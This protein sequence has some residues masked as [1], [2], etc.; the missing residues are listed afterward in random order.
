M[1]NGEDLKADL[2]DFVERFTEANIW[3]AGDVM[4]DEYIVGDVAR[5]SPEAPVQVVQVS[6]SFARLGGAANVARSISALAARVRLYG[7]VGTDPAGDEV[8]RRCG[9]TGIDATAVGRVDQHQTIRKTRIL[10]LRQQLLRLDWE[11]NDPC[12][13]ALSKSLIAKLEEG[14]APTAVIISDYGKGIVTRASI[15]ALIDAAEKAKVP[16]LVDPH[17]GDFSRYRGATILKPNLAELE[18]ATGRRLRGTT[19]AE[20]VEIVRDLLEG[21]GVEALVLTLS[22]RGMMVISRGRKAEI[23]PARPR[24]VYDVT[25][26][27]D[28]VIAVLALALSVGAGLADAA[29]IANAAA[30]IVI[31]EVGAASVEREELTA[32]LRGRATSKALSWLALTE[33]VDAWKRKGLRI[34]FTNGCFDLLHSGHLSLLRQAAEQGDVLVVGIN[35][36]PSVARLKGPERPL[37]PE[38]ERVAMLAALE[39]VDV[40]TVFDEDTPLELIQHVEPDVL[41]KGEDYKLDEVVGRE[42]VESHG[43]RV[44]LVPLLPEYSTSSLIDRLRKR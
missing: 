29:R 36:D 8:I 24:E 37:V 1:I 43:G 2:I 40:V 22:E 35:S 17:G 32:E 21:A 44:T 13:E 39:S 16:V 28:T 9:E 41:V 23:I 3:V 25:G 10:G 30:G 15:R 5:I 31:R 38:R 18:G 4:L 34:V 27:G 20:L 19:E 7:M 14:P 11:R 12:P 42:E 33:Q 26:A 6:E